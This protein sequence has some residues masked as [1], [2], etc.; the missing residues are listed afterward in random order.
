[1]ADRNACACGKAPNLIFAC[2]GAA[3]VGA[4]ADQAARR[5]AK[6]GAGKMFCLAGVGGRVSGIMETTRSAA[7]IL[8]IDGCSLNC[9]KSC[10]EQAGFQS[11]EHLQLA[12][13]GMEKGMTR[14]T[15]E[16]VARAAVA[17]AQKL[18]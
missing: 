12:D 15:E 3:D 17:G 4:V 18:A 16:T 1:M 8:A 14:P 5:L 7:R 9:A 11:F 10:L 2:S 13:L 6:S